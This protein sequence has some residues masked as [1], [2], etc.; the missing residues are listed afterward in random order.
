MERREFNFLESVV[1]FTEAKK[2]IE[3]GV[4]LGEMAVYLC[5][6]AH[7]NGG[8]YYGF[9]IWSTFGPAGQFQQV[10][11]KELVE[12]KLRA[13]GL[14][15]FEITKIDTITLKKEFENKL[16]TIGTIDFAFIDGDHSYAGIANDFFSVYPR[17]SKSGVIAF[18]DT[19]RIDGCREF[20]LDLH[21]K[22]YDGTFDLIDLPYGYGDRHCGVSLLSKRSLPVSNLPIDE[23]CGSISTP[24]E[25]EL[26]EKHWYENEIL[27]K[28]PMPKEFKGD[29][30]VD[31][32]AYYGG[33]KKFDE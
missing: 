28:P 12:Q 13:N 16:D 20:I 31:K 15:N 18:H 25:I 27:N 32:I 19:S 11:S 8:R 17:L 26:K 5:R 23:I 2:V 9:D 24:K 10:G 6:A 1:Y 30:K 7:N 29:L 4:Q 22:Y 3:V 33:R 14:N 21:T